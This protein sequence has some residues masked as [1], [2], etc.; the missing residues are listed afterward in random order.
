MMPNRLGTSGAP[1][2]LVVVFRLHARRA[3]RCLLRPASACAHQR[4]E[5]SDE[6]IEVADLDDSGDALPNNLSVSL[7]AL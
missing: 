1:I 3:A 2:R 7:I 5:H 6:R 4:N